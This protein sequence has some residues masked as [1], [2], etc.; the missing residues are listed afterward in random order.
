M[1]A[2][3]HPD[4]AYVKSL[5]EFQRQFLEQTM[6]EA[7]GIVSKAAIIA[8]LERTHLYKIADAC[9]FDL[10]SPRFAQMRRQTFANF[11]QKVAR[12]IERDSVCHF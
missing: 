7:G 11:R 3:N 12:A 10:T 9:G 1:G 6:H 8:G 5:R 2:F 4:R